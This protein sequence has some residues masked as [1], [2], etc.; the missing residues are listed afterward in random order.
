M[1]KENKIMTYYV[2]NGMV[3]SS[4]VKAIEAKN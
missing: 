1:I 4:L 3:F 2:V